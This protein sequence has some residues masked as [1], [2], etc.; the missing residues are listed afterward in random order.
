MADAW[1]WGFIRA[2]W[3]KYSLLKY[4]CG[5]EVVKISPVDQEGESE[6]TEKIDSLPEAK[7]AIREED[8]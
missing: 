1:P 3:R 5:A 8:R 7:A 2:A 6:S 4:R